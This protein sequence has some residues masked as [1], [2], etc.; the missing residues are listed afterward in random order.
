MSARDQASAEDVRKIARS[1]EPD[2]Y[3]AAL[4]APRDRRDDLIAFAALSADLRR[5]AG[6]ISEPSLGE[7]RVQW[8]REAI[9]GMIQGERSGQPLA[10]AVGD[11][12]RRRGIGIALLDDLFDATAHGLHASAPPD[13]DALALHLDMTEGALFRV[14]AAAL[15]VEMTD[16]FNGAIGHAAKAYG[17]ARIGMDLPWLLAR[18]R[19]PLPQ[20]WLAGEDATDYKAALTRLA[21]E[22]SAALSACREAVYGCPAALIT[23]LL[24]L[25]VVEPYLAALQRRGRDPAHDVAEIAPFSRVWRIG[26]AHFMARF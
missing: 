26:G 22:S 18:G 15:A 21:D 17:L 1:G 9:A 6:A 11:V 24:P 13:D 19:S 2:R 20:S 12:M 25:A 14:S 8:M 4:L 3:L 16:R 7:I 23:A 10:D 5:I